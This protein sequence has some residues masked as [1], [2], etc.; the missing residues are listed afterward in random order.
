MADKITLYHGDIPADLDLGKVIAIDSEAMGLKPKRDRLCLIQLS[1]GDG[2]AHLVQFK[3]GQYDAPNL[4]KMLADDSLLK[5][6]H[7]ARFDLAIIHEY[8]GIVSKNIYCTRTVSKLVRTYTDRHGLRENCRE[9]LGVDLNKQ[10]Q[11][12]NWGA[13]E[14]SEQQL[15]YAASD[16]FYL[17]DLKVRLDEMLTQTDRHDLAK[18]C[19]EF[20]PTQARL[21]LLGWGNEN[22]FDH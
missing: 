2:T 7:F 19:F 8:L 16:V 22:I 11:S 3:S 15:E 9:L 6:F 17:H 18:S 14:L 5:L 10:Q 12:S 4:K 21:D 20:L 13:P 1:S